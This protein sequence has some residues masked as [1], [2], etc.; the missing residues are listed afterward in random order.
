MPILRFLN[1]CFYRLKRLVFWRE[2]RQ[3]HFLGVFCLKGNVNKISN[4]RPKPWTNPFGK[5]WILW[6]FESDVFMVQRGLFFY[7][8]RQKS[9]FHDSFLRFITWAYMGLQGV[10]GGYK[11]LQGVWR[12]DRALQ[13]VR[14][15]YKGLQKTCFLTSKSPD[16][17][18]WSILHKNQSWRN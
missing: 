13:A 6:D 3:I 15:G 9:V 2:R 16:T 1:P 10:T 17:F 11:G 7:I 4:F 14:G 8:K 12:G 18:S 5:M